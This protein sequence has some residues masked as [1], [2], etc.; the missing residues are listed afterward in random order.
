M[1]NS[2]RAPG[3]VWRKDVS[4][5]GCR[6][7]LAVTATRDDE[8]Q[9]AG[10]SIVKVTNLPNSTS[11]VIHEKGERVS[12]PVIGLDVPRQTVHPVNRA[13]LAS[14]PTRLIPE[15]TPERAI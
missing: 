7:S 9:L 3:S 6:G 11:D 8:E 13:R 15:T 1:R 12:L 4:T 5:L 10:D 14:K 2:P